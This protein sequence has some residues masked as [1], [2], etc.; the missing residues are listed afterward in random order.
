MPR[1]QKECKKKVD[2]IFTKR[3]KVWFAIIYFGGI[4]NISQQ[5]GIG[6]TVYVRKAVSLI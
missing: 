1:K 5:I 2:F 4:K 3:S 6:K